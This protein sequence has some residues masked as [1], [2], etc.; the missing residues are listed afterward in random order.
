MT[1]IKFSMLPAFAALCVHS[2]ALATQP[3]ASGSG[4]AAAQVSSGGSM[5]IGSNGSALSYAASSQSAHASTT[6]ATSHTPNY[7]N[8]RASVAG[9][10]ATHSSGMAY[11]TSTG[12]GTGWANSAGAVSAAARG[13]VGIHGVNTGHS[14]G[15]TRT[16]STFV[17]QA[18]RDQ[19]SSVQGRTA[20]GFE[21][22]VGYERNGGVTVN[23]ATTGYVTGTNVSSALAGMNAAGLASI[24]ASGYFRG[25]GQSGGS[26]GAVPRP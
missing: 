18:G 12:S 16:Q 3:S 19:G 21:T 25:V 24:Q 22:V 20:S 26:T 23:A 14:G 5:S 11:N 1:F 4:G 15:S 9:E 10:T 6:T 7:S 2:A 13:T 8:V 17:I